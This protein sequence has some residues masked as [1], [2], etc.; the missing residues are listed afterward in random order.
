M[1]YTG[2]EEQHSITFHCLLVGTAAVLREQAAATKAAIAAGCSL[3]RLLVC[4]G[5]LLM[6]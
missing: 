3:S 1:Y 6:K 4:A 2:L 5:E